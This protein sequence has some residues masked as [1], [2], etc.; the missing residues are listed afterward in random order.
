MAAAAAS[1]TLLDYLE[2]RFASAVEQA[3]LQRNLLEDAACTPA[4]ALGHEVHHR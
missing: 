4:F 3:L 1:I 2:G